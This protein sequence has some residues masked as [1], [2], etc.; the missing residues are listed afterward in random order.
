MIAE[1]Y[2]DTE[3]GVIPVEWKVIKVGEFCDILDNKRVP[4]S[5]EQ[6]ADIKGNIPYYGANGVVDY[7]NDFL[8]DEELVLLAEDGGNFSEFETRPIA[9]M[10]D[11]KSWV[12]NHTHILRAKNGQNHFLFYNLVHKNITAFIN[13]GTRAKLN[14]GELVKIPIP[15]PPLKEQEKIADILSTSDAKI[16]AIASQIEKAE[17]LKKGLLQKLLSEGIGHSEFKDSEL[18]RIPESWEVVELN[19]LCSKIVGGGTPNSKIDDYWKNG[20]IYWATVKDMDNSKYLSKT[21]DTITDLGLKN[22]SA[23]LIP[24]N[25]IIT[26][27]RMGLGRFFINTVDMAINQD[28]KALIIKERYD[29]NFIFWSLVS[30]S[31]FILSLGTGTTVKGI[32][33]E[34]FKTIKFTIP[35]L[36]EQKQIADILSTADEKLEVLRAK[37][38]KYETLKKGLLQKLLSG[39]VRV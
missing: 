16:D 24:A 13:G 11:G 29:K 10:I 28:L 22:S 7:I 25:S 35:P 33:L 14:R 23:N 4:L 5:S 3:I 20:T 17:T 26:A 30:K 15:L 36:K 2:K 6:R 8:F 37:K 31:D 1:G 19:D 34:E 27:T 39:E 38:E 21:Q 18:G 9:Y 32:R 12:N